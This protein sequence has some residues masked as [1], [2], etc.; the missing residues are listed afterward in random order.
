V[1]ERATKPRSQQAGH[2]RDARALTPATGQAA[3]VDASTID[4]GLVGILDAVVARRAKSA[5]ATQALVAVA[6]L[7]GVATLQPAGGYTGSSC[8]PP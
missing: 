8:T 1:G 5:R 4:V 7:G 3:A 6:V 2:P